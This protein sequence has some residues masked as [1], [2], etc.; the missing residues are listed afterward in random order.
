MVICASGP[1]RQDEPNNQ[2]VAA[3]ILHFRILQTS[4]TTSFP[5]EATG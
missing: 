1:V 3:I 4:E 2:D 5:P